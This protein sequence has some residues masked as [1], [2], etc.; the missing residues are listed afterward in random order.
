MFIRK[1]ILSLVAAS[2]A[3]IA[4]AQ[5]M[6]KDTTY[7][8]KKKE[9]GLNFNQGSFSNS[10]QGGGVNNY[11]FG[12]FFNAKAEYLK[13]RDNWTND[14]QSQFGFQ[15][16]KGQDFRKSIDRIF[17]DSKYGRRLGKGPDGKWFFVA[18]F[19]FLSQFANGF[20]Y[21]YT[22]KD[23]TSPR[24][25][26]FLAPMFLTEA[27]GVEWKPTKFFNLNFMPGAV[28]H[29]I[30][31]DKNM[32]QDIDQ[33]NLTQVEAGKDPFDFKNYGVTRGKAVRTEV[34][35]MQLVANFDKDIAKNVNLKFRYQAFASFSDL[36]AIDNRLDAK[37]TAK[38]NRYLNFSFDLIALYDQDQVNKIQFAQAMGLGFLYTF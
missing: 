31:A 23:G 17:F 8:K 20:D 9:F 22:Y 21:N 33:K 7:W 19:N 15:K 2:L 11:G 34:A 27:V 1:S 29:T 13:D 25:A 10:W 4:V 32:Y 30:L 5:E 35:L 24:M 18:N 12:S 6:P 37:L 26:G 36:A 28:R 14:F 38:I 3:T 16:I